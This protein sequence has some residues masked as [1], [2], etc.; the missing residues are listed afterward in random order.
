[1]SKVKRSIDLGLVIKLD[2]PEGMTERAL[3][4]AVFN[5]M[6]GKGDPREGVNMLADIGYY[7]ADKIAENLKAVGSEIERGG[8][9]GY[10]PKLEGDTRTPRQRAIDLEARG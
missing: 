3:L 4:D 1:M 5:A 2:V 7:V 8:G 6:G 10:C 9:S